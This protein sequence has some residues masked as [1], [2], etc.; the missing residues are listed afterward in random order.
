ME[1]ATE[2]CVTGRGMR[3]QVAVEEKG[4][5]LLVL[6]QSD[7]CIRCLFKISIKLRPTRKRLENSSST[8]IPVALLVLFRLV[9]WVWC[10]WQRTLNENKKRKVPKEKKIIIKLVNSK[11]WFK[12]LLSPNY[13]PSHPI[14]L[15][16]AF[17]P[18]SL[19]QPLPTNSPSCSVPIAKV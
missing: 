10:T 3:E 9:L 1:A 6:K 13:A 15:H 19:A 7:I 14:L 11:R 5:L 17:T 18:S 12:L 4:T 16:L 2:E 8:L